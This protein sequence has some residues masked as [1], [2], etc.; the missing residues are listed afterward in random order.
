MKLEINLIVADAKAAGDYYQNL[1]NAEILS[2]TD[3][4]TA[5]NETLMKLGGT[6]IRV[7]NENKDFGL[8][9]PVEGTPASI[10]INLFV[11]DIDA[12][13]DNV[14]AMGCKVLS[15]VQEFPQIPAKNAVFSDQF[16]HIWVVNQQ[17]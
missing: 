17:Y 11:A 14:V 6:E 7:L 15:P 4:A 8:F 3:E 9:A 1:L 13:F 12:F 2:Q 16:N 10:G 5:M